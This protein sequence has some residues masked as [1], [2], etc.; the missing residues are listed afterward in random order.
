MKKVLKNIAAI[1][2]ALIP[3]IA[4]TSAVNE[5]QHESR[6]AV[7]LTCPADLQ[8]LVGSWAN[9][10]AVFDPQ[11]D[12]RLADPATTGTSPAFHAI[13][14]GYGDEMP[15]AY[16]HFPYEMISVGRDVFVPVINAENPY[17]AEIME[18]GIGL[19]DLRATFTGKG[20][21]WNILIEGAEPSTIHYYLA[22]DDALLTTVGEF[23]GVDLESINTASRENVSSVLASVAS[24]PLAI[25]FCHLKDIVN[26]MEDTF[27]DGILVLPLDRNENGKLDA[28][29]DFN[30]TPS[31]FNRAVWI[32]KYP[33][34][35]VRDLYCAFDANTV[36]DNEAAFMKWLVNEGQSNL[37]GYGLM[38]L[39]TG[40]KHSAIAHIPTERVLP[41]VAPEKYP[42]MKFVI[43]ILLAAII[44]GIVIRYI[45]NSIK[46]VKKEKEAYEALKPRLFDEGSVDI[47]AGI[48]FDKSHTWAFMEKNGQVRI[49]V[50]DFLPHVTG[51]LSAIRMKQP[52]DQVKKG[53]DILTLVQRGKKLNIKSPVSGTVRQHN[54]A[55]RENPLL[56]SSSPYSEGWVYLV[57]PANWLREVQFMFMADKFRVWISGEFGRLRDFLSIMKNFGGSKL[58]TVVLQDGG[59]VREG[60]LEDMG[61][62]AWEEFQTYFIEA[63]S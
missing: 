29:E 11:S 13:F 48:F 34:A 57:E 20:Q 17:R 44:L 52:G 9:E 43:M 53:E 24:D 10:F 36:R 62:E 49:G 30:R 40:E 61:P 46:S 55:L 3:L 58:S 59:R 54:N 42:Y 21:N 12:V 39:T 23:L 41:L 32:G 6:E 2:L 60:A 7:V 22:D 19:S 16:R 63:T 18:Q 47:P 33:G 56:I 28:I 1:S 14:I 35:L 25:G 27:V 38:Q 4:V 8:G 45:V 15:A 5:D 37:E 50:D 51:K 26:E 31:A